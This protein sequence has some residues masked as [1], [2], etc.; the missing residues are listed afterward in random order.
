M[1][2]RL[3]DAP[4]AEPSQF[5]GFAGNIIDRQ[6]E[7]R[8]DDSVEKALAD[9]ATRLL[10]M[11]SGRILLKFDP[12]GQAQGY[13]TSAEAVTLGSETG[14][15]VLLGFSPGGPVV[16]IPVAAEPEALPQTIFSLR[17]RA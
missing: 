17:E 2:F 11:G 7:N 1:P 14:N 10:L 12:E 5:V 13:F 4:Q 15:A 6:S 16:A 8:A 3:F 9:P